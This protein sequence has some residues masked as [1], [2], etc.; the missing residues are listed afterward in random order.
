[1]QNF[2]DKPLDEISLSWHRATLVLLCTFYVP[3]FFYIV[4]QFACHPWALM[5][6]A[7]CIISALASVFILNIYLSSIGIGLLI[8][9]G[10]CYTPVIVLL[11]QGITSISV[12]GNPWQMDMVLVV[13]IMFAFVPLIMTLSSIFSRWMLV[14]HHGLELA[15]VKTSYIPTL[16]VGLAALLL[17]VYQY[18]SVISVF[19]LMFSLGGGCSE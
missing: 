17:C 9:L 7:I 16:A 12:L 5:A 8:R 15:I 11:I 2:R 13:F 3:T 19:R 10:I 18:A 14:V 1:M 4:G 6:Q